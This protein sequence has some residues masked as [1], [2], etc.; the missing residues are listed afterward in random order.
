[1]K[2]RAKVPSAS[3]RERRNREG[4]AVILGSVG[5]ESMPASDTQEGWLFERRSGSLRPAEE[6][7]SVDSSEAKRIA[8][9]IVGRKLQPGSRHMGQVAGW[10][11][12]IQVERRRN[13]AVPAGQ[14]A[15]CSLDRSARP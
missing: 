3:A 8:E 12:R 10:I 9:Q 1:M 6:E 11:G 7:R 14:R 2:T 5:S 15:D 4:I 13:P